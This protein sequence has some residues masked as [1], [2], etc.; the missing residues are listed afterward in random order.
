[1]SPSM[2]RRAA[3]R[4]AA[5]VRDTAT[6]PLAQHLADILSSYRPDGIATTTWAAIQ[7]THADVMVRSG[8]VGRDSFKKQLKVVALYLS[9]RQ[10]QGGS[11]ELTD[12][13]AYD[14]IDS[15][16]LNGTSGLS[17]KT[18]N[19][20]RSR[21][22]NIA[23]HAN[24]GLAAAPQIA[25]LGHRSVRPGYTP[26]EAGALR[27]IALRQS[28][29]AQ[30]RNLCAVIGLCQGAGLD[31]QDLRGLVRRDVRDH[32]DAGIEIQVPG[33]RARTT[34][35]RHDHEELV[36]AGID[37]IRPDA[38]VLGRVADRRNIVSAIVDKADLFDD[39]PHIEA[40]RLRATW[41]TV[42]MSDRVPVKVILDAAGLRSARTL[43]ELIAAMPAADI[44]NAQNLLRGATS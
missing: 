5:A 11:M 30:R 42:L 39:V 25:K 1:M 37:G 3:Q 28:R 32:G 43:T 29:P 6:A 16:Y 21:M 20:Y 24:P 17:D 33:N 41:L 23:A 31:S 22:R 2:S 26:A 13:L 14:L 4:R 9:W 7:P 40:S 15:W 19:D 44:A 36:R 34:W 27:R 10:D 18:R 38:L 8:I 12:A 35:V